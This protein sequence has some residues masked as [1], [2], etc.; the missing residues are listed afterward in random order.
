[1][2]IA[3]IDIGT[4]TVLMVIARSNGSGS[5]ETIKNEFTIPRIGKGLVPGGPI[6]EDK[7]EL[8]LDIIKKFVDTAKYYK[9]DKIIASATNAFRIASNS[10]EIAE[11]IRNMGVEIEVISG[12]KESYFAYL[13]AVS[14]FDKDEEA[15]VM[16]IGGGSTEIIYGKGEN[17]HYRKSFQTG[18]VSLTEKF[19]LTD[20]PSPGDI[21]SVNTEL[22]KIFRELAEKKFS[23]SKAIAIAGTPT[24]LACIQQ[25][26]S[27]FDEEA[28]EGSCLKK[29]DIMGMIT[30]I[31]VLSSEEILKKYSTV[32]KGR[33][34]VLLAGTLI[35]FHLLNILGLSEVNVS[36]KGIRYGAIIN[37][38]RHN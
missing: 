24:T 18:V 2:I 16:D 21:N 25:G 33:E 12:E 1:M 31:S 34:D 32:V 23:P 17:I 20:P 5:P 38:F 11:L 3:S 6:R 9:A 37:Y 35:L 28:I 29:D 19:F 4:N 27:S 26:L 8:L 14:G 36:T 10:S 13:G 7:K 30:E 22:Q 15:L